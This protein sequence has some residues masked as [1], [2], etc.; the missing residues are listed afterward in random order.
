MVLSAIIQSISPNNFW[1]K[2]FP[3]QRRALK[4]IKTH[5]VILRYLS[6]RP[7]SS[8]FDRGNI[9]ALNIIEGRG[10]EVYN[11][12]VDHTSLSWST[13]EVASIINQV[14][15]VSLQ[16]NIIAEGL[17]DSTNPE[18]AHSKGLMMYK[19]GQGNIS[20]HHNL[21]AHNSLGEY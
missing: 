13:D 2:I 7:G 16:W 8:Q 3:D 1:N 18:G 10:S 20:V 6:S 9:D 12:V 4:K 19:E 21:L 14:Q 11:V 17:D 15:D 5:D